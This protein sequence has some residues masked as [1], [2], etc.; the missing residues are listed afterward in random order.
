MHTVTSRKDRY[1]RGNVANQPI[2]LCMHTGGN[3]VKER[4]IPS[5]QCGELGTSAPL[6]YMT[7]SHY[8]IMGSLCGCDLSS[9]PGK[10]DALFLHIMLIHKWTKKFF[11]AKTLNGNQII[12]LIQS[13]KQAMQDSSCSQCRLRNLFMNEIVAK[14]N[15]NLL[16]YEL[17]FS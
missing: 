11:I 13:M 4:P 15:I 10:Q 9:P 7:D 6:E 5:M 12:P 2:I 17:S 14:P 8:S 16:V 3:H 1:R